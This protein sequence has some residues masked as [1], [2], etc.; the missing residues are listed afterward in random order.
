M[1]QQGSDGPEHV[2]TSRDSSSERA[3]F[4]VL[5]VGYIRALRVQ[6]GRADWL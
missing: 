2:R 5:G 3:H 4:S 1:V 6:V